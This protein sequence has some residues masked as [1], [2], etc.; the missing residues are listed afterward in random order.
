LSEERQPHREAVDHGRD[1]TRPGAIPAPG[2][3]DVLVRVK[4]RI[5]ENNLSIVAAGVAFYALIATF[6]GLLALLEMYGLVFD[7]GQ[8]A[9]QMDFLR[10]Q[11]EP[12]ANS[13]VV[14]LL[15]GLGESDRAGAGFGIVGGALITLWGA[16]LGSRALIRALNVAY[17]E[18]EKRSVVH[19]YG[20]ALLLTMG[21]ISVAFCIVL[22]LLSVPLLT[23]WLE[24]SPLLQ[25]F[26][27]YARWPAV[28]LLFWLSLQVFYRYGTSR[29][30]ARWSWVSW[31]AL[32]A[33]VTWLV[34]TGVLAWYVAG[35]R[36]YHQA[37]GSV[38]IVVLVLAWFL[39]SA[40]SV[41]LGA[42]VNAELERQT[43]QDTTVGD[44][45]PAGARGA[46]VADTLGDASS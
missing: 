45:K 15:R 42:E 18:R 13:L 1:A 20:L 33:T 34:G 24:L 36:R 25:R 2:W 17:G 31:G 37:Y 14:F 4:R 26:V 28:G 12:E 21:A 8:L 29:A 19:R 38:G 9:E 35:S 10:R 16:S 32:L 46:I 39:V 7:P 6:P 41:L 3:R 43:R 5:A 44:D 23:R 11:L 27:F 40:F 30:P 22:V